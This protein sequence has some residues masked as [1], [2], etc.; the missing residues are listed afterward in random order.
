MGEA[1]TTKDE[2]V[3][4][5]KVKGEHTVAE[6]ADVLEITEMAIRRHLSNLE[7]DGL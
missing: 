3:Q 7:K 1:R 6:L 2:I 4:L 5:L